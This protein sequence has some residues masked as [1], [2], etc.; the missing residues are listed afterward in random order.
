MLSRHGRHTPGEQSRPARARADT[1]PHAAHAPPPAKPRASTHAGMRTHAQWPPG[2][3]GQPGRAAR[4]R[5]QAAERGG[6]RV[7]DQ[8]QLRGAAHGAA[9]RGRLRRHAHQQPPAAQVLQH[10]R[11]LRWRRV[12]VAGPSRTPRGHARAHRPAA[13]PPARPP[14]RPLCTKLG[15]LGG[16]DQLR[17]SCMWRPPCASCGKGTKSWGCRVRLQGSSRASA[18]VSAPAHRH[19]CARGA[20]S[21]CTGYISNALFCDDVLHGAHLARLRPAREHLQRLHHDEP[22]HDRVGRGDRV[23]DVPGHAL[24]PRRAPCHAGHAPRLADTTCL[25]RS[26]PRHAGRAPRLAGTACPATPHRRLR[27]AAASAPTT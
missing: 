16:S 3:G 24:R 19:W 26:A 17:E 2:R 13:S 18:A 11:H 23:D 15:I 9:G 14:C 1:Q 27:R 4:L 7:D 6:A 20:A 22:A 25:A 12:R 10:V 8:A 21:P 5:H